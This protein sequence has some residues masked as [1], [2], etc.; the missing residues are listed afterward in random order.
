M[1]KEITKKQTQLAIT[2]MMEDD[3]KNK[4]K[5]KQINKEEY[6]KGIK[7][8]NLMKKDLGV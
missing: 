4:Y 3:I 1:D 2:L 6:S 5:N 7:L 8:I